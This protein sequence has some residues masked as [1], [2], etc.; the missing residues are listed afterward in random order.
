MN[1]EQVL[2]KARAVNAGRDADERAMGLKAASDADAFELLGVA[3]AA[4][5]AGVSRDDWNAVAEGLAMLHQVREKVVRINEER[6]KSGALIPAAYAYSQI[7]ECGLALKRLL[8]IAISLC[9]EPED[10][11][12][13]DRFIDSLPQEESVQ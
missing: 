1:L 3:L 8:E 5:E 12:R 7:R 10:F 4:I 11:I 9:H 6:T 13:L 2:A